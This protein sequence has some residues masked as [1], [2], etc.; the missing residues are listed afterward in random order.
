M[1][2]LIAPTRRLRVTP[3]ISDQACRFHT[4]SAD[5]SRK[6][7]GSSRPLPVIRPAE[8]RTFE[9]CEADG[10]FLEVEFGCSPPGYSATTGALSFIGSLQPLAKTVPAR[11]HAVVGLQI[12]LDEASPAR[13]T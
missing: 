9:S 7:D 11:R 4:A 6:A 3:F 10:R 8:Y 2:N 13:V 1:P 5:P 12:E